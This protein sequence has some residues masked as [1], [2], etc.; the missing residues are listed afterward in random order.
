M[1]AGGYSQ[2][3]LESMEPYNE[4][5]RT[6]TGER[7]LNRGGGARTGEVER[8]KTGRAVTGR[9]GRTEAGIWQLVEVV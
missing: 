3:E 2:G 6:V 7:A 1:G 4:Q 9:L 8:V 5:D